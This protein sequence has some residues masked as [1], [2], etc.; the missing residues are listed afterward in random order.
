M[1]DFMPEGLGIGMISPVTIATKY[2]AFECDLF[3]HDRHCLKIQWFPPI[4]SIHSIRAK[5][6]INRSRMMANATNLSATKSECI[7]LNNGSL[8]TIALQ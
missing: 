6:S 8:C 4:H 3:N 5:I 1:M 7:S 2:R